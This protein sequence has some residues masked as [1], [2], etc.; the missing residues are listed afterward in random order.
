MGVFDATQ[1]VVNQSAGVIIGE[2]SIDFD[3]LW[4]RP[5]KHN[6]KL[7]TSG[8]CWACGSRPLLLWG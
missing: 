1:A 5:L 6:W 3:T 8:R 7:W 2:T 4:P